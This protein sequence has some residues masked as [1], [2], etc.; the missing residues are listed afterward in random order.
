MSDFLKKILWVTDFSDEAQD[1]LI[2]ADLF[3]KTFEAELLA[4][5]VVPD[6]SP[7]LYNTATA[8]E[9]ELV[10]RVD[11]IKNDAAE[12]LDSISKAEDIS[13]RS[14]VKEG[15]AAKKI[16]ETAEEENVD[17]IVMGRK[18]MSALERIFIGSV[19]NQVLRNSRVPLLL[20]KKTTGGPRFNK[21][22]VPT[23]FSEHE[24]IERDFAWKLAKGLDAAL[25]LLHVLELHD[26]EFSPRVLEEMMGEIL[27]RIKGRKR[28]EK[29]DVEVTED[30]TRAVNASLGIMDYAA[31]HAYDLI[32]MSTCGP[33]AVERFFLGSTT[34]KVIAH[35][36]IPIFAIPSQFCKA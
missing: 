14:L 7:A 9:G 19:A 26:Y 12:H 32:V 21:I 4:L 23:D 5:H 8:I 34:E 16:I 17:L 18:G 10:R 24:D 25:T 31:A 28:S 6:F 3:A 11:V 1:G 13:F 22:L 20:T 33:G 29:E 2:S 15:N 36:P 30:V 27:K 35:S